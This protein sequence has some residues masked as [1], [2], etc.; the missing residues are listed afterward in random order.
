M[1]S[2]RRRQTNAKKTSSRRLCCD[3]ADTV[4]VPFQIV[5]TT[6]IS[7]LLP[8]SFLLLARLST[9]QYILSATNNYPKAAAAAVAEPTS[10]LCSFFLNSKKP[11]IL[12]ILVTLITVSS[13]S[14]AL[15]GKF[16]LLVNHSSDHIHPS[17]RRRRLYAAW[18]FLFVFQVCVGLWIEGSIATGIDGSGFGRENSFLLRVV[19]FFG[20]HETIVFWGRT[21]VKPVV[22]DTI[23][24]YWRKEG[25][26][27]KAAVGLS[28]GWFWW[29]RL[30]DE[31]EAL[32]V[33]PSLKTST[34]GV[35]VGVA[36]F[37]GWC[38]Y[39]LTVTIGIVRIV[40]VFILTA[41]ILT[42]RREEGNDDKV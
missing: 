28:Y 40:R 27:E 20:L 12:H 29:W 6:L 26:V 24:G 37:M 5:T 4:R 17:T 31:V 38:L 33:V 30:R 13:L 9:A 10:L 34:T 8:L 14:Y 42:R 1:E 22:D 7:L 3:D 32:V 39:Y 23:F 11:T 35:G 18:W 2:S 36:D 16:I 21:V 41:L 25:W 19:F 15:T